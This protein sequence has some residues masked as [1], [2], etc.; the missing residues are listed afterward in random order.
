MALLADLSRWLRKH[1]R[2]ERD[3]TATYDAVDPESLLYAAVKRGQLAPRLHE[4]RRRSAA[5]LSRLSAEIGMD[6]VALAVQRLVLALE[7]LGELEEAWEAATEHSRCAQRRQALLRRAPPRLSLHAARFLPQEDMI[8]ISRKLAAQKFREAVSASGLAVGERIACVP[9][10]PAARLTREAYMEAARRGTP[11][12]IEGL[13]WEVISGQ[14]R[15]AA[16]AW[17]TVTPPLTARSVDADSACLSR[18]TPSRASQELPSIEHPL[19]WVVWR[20]RRAAGGLCCSDLRW[21]LRRRRWL[22]RRRLGDASPRPLHQ[23][24]ALLPARSLTAAVP[25]GAP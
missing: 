25:A 17:A 5:F 1:R 19:G 24:H 8:R 3:T 6:S 18:G 13:A 21:R 11:L 20:V 12:V 14:V 22:W 4:E 16:G 23:P 10:I 15:I 7:L 9:R 2:G